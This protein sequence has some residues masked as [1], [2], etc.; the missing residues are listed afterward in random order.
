MGA[1][2]VAAYR[3]VDESA[4]DRVLAPFQRPSFSLEPVAIAWYAVAFQVRGAR[5]AV[6][7]VPR[8]SLRA[9]LDDLDAGRLDE[10]IASFL[11]SPPSGRVLRSADQLSRPGLFD[12]LSSPG[13]IVPPERRPGRGRLGGIGRGTP[14]D[15]RRNKN[16]GRRPRVPRRVFV[17]AAATVVV[18]TV[19]ATVAVASSGGGS[20]HSVGLGVPVT[21]VRSTVPRPNVTAADSSPPSSLL[22]ASPACAQEPDLKSLA[23]DTPATIDLTN[24]TEQL[25]HAYWLNYEGVRTFYEDIPPHGHF[26]QATFVTHPWVLADTFQRCVG[27]AIVIGPQAELRVPQP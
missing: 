25:L 6:V 3:P 14:S 4:L 9:F 23:G 20:K 17:A 11:A 18:V 24:D 5:D 12:E 10:V 13:A 2:A 1:G 21:T 27:L 7:G 19:I 26:A 22:A 8:R 16:R 15:A